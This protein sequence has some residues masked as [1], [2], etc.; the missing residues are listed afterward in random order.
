MKLTPLILSGI[1]SLAVGLPIAGAAQTAPAP[2][3]SAASPGAHAHHHNGFMRALR[4]VNLSDQ[5]KTQIQQIMSQYKSQH[6]PGSPRDPQA[7]QQLHQQ[8]MNVL[9]PDQRTQVQQNLQQ[10][11]QDREQN[12]SQPAP[13]ASPS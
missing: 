11:R 3:A 2:A 8:V 6:Q 5:Q 10:M 1:L 12:G 13:V 9:T 4:G 7:M